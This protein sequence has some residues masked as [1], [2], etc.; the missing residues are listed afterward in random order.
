MMQILKMKSLKRKIK[1]SLHI[2]IPKDKITMTVYFEKERD[3]KDA[4]KIPFSCKGQKF[5]WPTSTQITK[6]KFSINRL[7]EE[8]TTFM[9][10]STNIVRNVTNKTTKHLN[11]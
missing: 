2:Y 3:F 6:E 9:M 10:E 11:V 8:E 1:T 7:R 5:A 4:I